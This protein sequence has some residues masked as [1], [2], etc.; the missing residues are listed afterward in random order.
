VKPNDAILAEEKHLPIYEEIQSLNP[1]LVP[2]GAAQNTARG[3]QYM[4]PTNSVVFVGCVG[5]DVYAA[6]LKEG[7]AKVGLRVEYRVDPDTPTG[8][9]AVLINGAHN[10]NR[11]MVTD[12]AAANKYTLDHLKSP[13]VWALVEAAKVYY[14][15][16]Y[17]FTVCPPAIM[18]LAE[19]AAARNKTFVLSLSAPFIPL[20]FKDPVAAAYPY[21]DYV[22]GNDDEAGAF[23]TAFGLGTTDIK[24]IAQKMADMPKENS[25]QKRTVIITRGTQSTIVAV[26]GGAEVREFPVHIIPK[27]NIEDTTG[28]GDAFAGGLCAGLLE[29]KSLETSIDMGQWLAKLSLGGVGAT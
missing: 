8:R 26:Q 2:G 24:E 12:L 16:G 21:V 25:Q 5:D 10:E 3:A 19:E 17:H 4:L 20:A 6:R 9:C 18:A 15:G 23:A 29:A 7:N 14:I 13:A 11:S 27:D 22:L 1:V 28:A